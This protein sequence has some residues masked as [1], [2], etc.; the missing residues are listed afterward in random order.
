MS[1]HRL[2]ELTWQEAVAAAPT[3][4]LAVPLGATEQ[5]GPHLPIGTDA[6]IATALAERLAAQRDD[7][8]VAPTVAYGSSGEHAAFP[9]TLSIG[10]P[11]TTAVVLELVRSADDFR[12]V[13]LVC[14]HG[15]NAE[16]VRAAVAVLTA[17]GRDVLDWTPSIAGGDAHAGRTETAL[18][19][20]LDPSSVR[21][22][23]L[24]AGNDRPLAE[25]LPRLRAG[26]VAAVSPNGVLGDPTGASA[27]EGAALLG[28][29]TAQLVTAV[30]D[31][32]P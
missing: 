9:G 25:L 30:G 7:V 1:S 12:G 2:A 16:A 20:A 10:G 3:S 32:W 5:H 26:G 17:E 28:A 22:D 21:L 31:R 11:A 15:G 4:I 13:V 27:D 19:L 18:L 23:E 8:L 6:T 14:G 24:E 29:L